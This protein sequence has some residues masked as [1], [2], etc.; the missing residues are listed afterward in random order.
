VSHGAPAGML[1][2][3]AG[4]PEMARRHWSRARRW[5]CSGKGTATRS[6]GLASRAQG[7]AS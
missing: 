3:G 7:E 2:V 1:G 6:G 4:W 5:G